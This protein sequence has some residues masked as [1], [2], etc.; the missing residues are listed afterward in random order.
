MWKIFVFVMIFVCFATANSFQWYSGNTW[1]FDSC[2]WCAQKFLHGDPGVEGHI[3]N[4]QVHINSDA[5]VAY[6]KM[7]Y[8]LGD[9]SIHA[10]T[11]HR[12]L[13]TSGIFADNPNCFVP[14]VWFLTVGVGSWS[15]MYV[16]AAITAP[17]INYYNDGT[18]WFDNLNGDYEA[19]ITYQPQNPV[20]PISLGTIKANYH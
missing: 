20:E 17:G 15:H 11:L 18:T 4:I 9:D 1:V 7:G 13:P 8:Y 16:D 10:G 5:D 14:A 6:Y 2:P 3:S 19:I 12:T